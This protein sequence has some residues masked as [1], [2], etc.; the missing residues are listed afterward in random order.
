MTAGFKLIALTPKGEE[1]IKKFVVKDRRVLVT[2]TCED[3][4]T[5]AF[6]FA[7]RMAKYMSNPASI[8]W[9]IKQ[10]LKGYGCKVDL[11]YKLEIK[12]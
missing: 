6:V 10:A 4:L 1:A 11:D 2:R 3:P 8:N 9:F 7:G 12:E 5:L